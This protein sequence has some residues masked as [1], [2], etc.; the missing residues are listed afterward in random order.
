MKKYFCFLLIFLSLI[1]N[2]C[3]NNNDLTNRVYSGALLSSQIIND[4]YLLQQYIT[5]RNDEILVSDTAQTINPAPLYASKIKYSAK[6]ID[7]VTLTL[8]AD[9]AAP[10]HNGVTLQATNICE[11]ANYVFVSYNTAGDSFIGAIQDIQLTNARSP[12][13][14]SQ[15]IYH[16]SDVS[17]ITLNGSREV[18]LAMATDID[19]NTQFTRPALMGAISLNAQFAFANN[20]VFKEMLGYAAVSVEVWD[21]KI[22]VLSGDNAGLNVFDADSYD[23]IAYIPIPDARD[24]AFYNN[25]IY[26]YSGAPGTLYKINPSNYTITNTYF[27]GG[28]NKTQEKSSIV[29]SGKYA[30]IAANDSGVQIVNLDN[31]S[32]V[33]TINNPTVAGL[34]ADS[35][36]ANSVTVNGSYIFVA[37]GEAG[38]RVFKNTTGNISVANSLNIQS[39]GFLIL[40]LKQSANEIYCYN[41]YLV[42]A[43]GIGG[44]KIIAVSGM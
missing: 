9:I 42:V 16:N 19:A 12:R 33:Y 2:G 20:K 5:Y 22:F 4:E 32:L 25:F 35:V 38:V 29:I 15:V 37:N 18:I 34:S 1:F 26:V 40:G 6:K 44:I 39:E 27:L 8:V 24:I 31:G 11:K 36:V 43:S 3:G 28:S 23:S 13:L 41:D 7:G 21:N 14:I 30:F 10:V 17:A